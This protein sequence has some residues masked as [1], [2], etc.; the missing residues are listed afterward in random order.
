[1]RFRRW[2]RPTRYEDTPRK[3]AA[4]VRKQHLEREALPLFAEAVAQ[5]QPDIET[6]MASRAERW[7]AR[8]Q[9]TRQTRAER[10]R[11][12]RARLF[13]L[14]DEKR[15]AARRLWRTCPYPGD[16][17]SFGDF[18]RGIA[19]GRIDPSQPPWVYVPLEPA[20]SKPS[21]ATF[22]QAFKQIGQ[23]RVGGGPKTTGA[24]ELLF[25]GNLGTGILFLR[26]RVRLSDPRESFLTSSNHRLRDSHVG[27]AGH[28]VDIVVAGACDDAQLA[29]IE[30][31]AQA[32]DTRPVRVRRGHPA[33]LYRRD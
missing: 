1:M 4:F 10:W 21:P 29:Q 16:P 8:E 18:L 11:D 7:D 13:A 33:R 31:L 5:R 14:P 27:R 22:D 3:R 12:G 25:V 23:R 28:W 17:S 6:E 20:R 32:A 30:A 26:S 24:D 2:P 15:A 19:D 9:A